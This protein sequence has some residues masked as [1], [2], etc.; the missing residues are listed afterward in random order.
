MWLLFALQA[1]SHEIDSH[2]CDNRYN[3][4]LSRVTSDDLCR[5]MPALD[6]RWCAT[7]CI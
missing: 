7:V 2:T 3:I 4:K 6:A 1:L 5:S